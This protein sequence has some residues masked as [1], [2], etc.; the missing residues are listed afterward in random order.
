MTYQK[1]LPFENFNRFRIMSVQKIRLTFFFILMSVTQL[2]A[3]DSL[4][5]Q[6]ALNYALKNSQVIEKA[7][8][9][10]IGGQ[11]KVK[12]VRAGALPQIDV[13][14]TATYNLLVQQFILPAEFMGGNP[15]EFISVKAGQSWGAMTQV[16]LN[17]QLFNQSVF[18]GLKAAKSSE[19]Y[20]RLAAA[21]S[22]ENVLQ[23]VAANYYQV[24]I[25]E[26]KLHVID[27]NI[28]RTEK[29]LTIVTDQYELGL[30][31]KI[32]L[33]RM[34]VNRSNLDAQRQELQ[35]AI[36]QQKNL[37]KYYMGMP[38]E[39]EIHLP[40]QALAQLEK[41]AL[42]ANYD[43]FNLERLAQYKVL[44]SQ[45]T[46]LQYQRKA[47]IA[48]YYP[49]LS[50]GAN[51]MLNSQ[52]NRFDLYTSKALNYDMSAITLT[53]KVPIFDGF[54][55][56]S[57]VKQA[58]VELLKVNQDIQNTANSLKMAYKNATNQLANSLTTIK[59]QAANKELAKE[60]YNSTQN[61][62]RNGLASLTDLLTSETDLVAAQNSYNEALLNYKVAQIELIKSNGNIKSLLAN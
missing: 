46:L 6:Q 52:S 56:R 5:L 15:G 3:Q 50:L 61:N 42:I 57:R 35:T 39:Q 40:D 37:L 13:T 22:E 26:E 45:E 30:A 48:E 34:K 12:E 41:E 36:V 43:S 4:T 62:Y 1:A 14:S 11:E 47:Y 38:V 8:L 21:V 59:T 53:L 29:L 55:R 25:N 23:Q 54:A 17:Q 24:I 9:E 33:D 60:V 2:Y 27:A 7:R 28:D 44:K 19:E 49:N 20:Y 18:T 51:Y 10:I 58:N 32:D 31:K 16:Q